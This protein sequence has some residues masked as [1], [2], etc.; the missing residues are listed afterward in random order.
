MKKWIVLKRSLPWGLLALLAVSLIVSCGGSGASGASSGPA[1]EKLAAAQ[2][3]NLL[4]FDNR[5]YTLDPADT[6]MPFE[7]LVI[8]HTIEGLFRTTVDEQGVQ[9]HEPAGAESYTVSDDGMVYTFKL[10]DYNW[11]D[12]KPVT[13]Q[14][15]VD[16][17]VRLLAPENAFDYVFQ[18][19][20]VKNAEAFY[21]KEVTADKLGIKALDDK[22]LEITLGTFSPF[23][24]DKLNL[25]PHFP[26]RLDVIGSNADQ[27][28]GSSV[29]KSLSSGPFK[30]SSWVKDNSIT[31]VKNPA[32]WDAANVKLEK[33][34]LQVVD[35]DSTRAQLFNNRQLD[36]VSGA[37][38]Y[39][40]TWKKQADSG[41]IVL[42][43]F[44]NGRLVRLDFPFN[45]GIAGLTD[46]K[47]I[48]Q[49]LSLSIDR[50]EAVDLAYNGRQV[51]AYGLLP[52]GLG[53][54]GRPA[55]DLVPEPL[56]GL[57]ARYV[58]DTEALRALFL[59]GLKE[60]GYSGGLDSITLQ[61]F[62]TDTLQPLKVLQEYL[63]QTWETR[64]GIHINI[65]IVADQGL[66]FTKLAGKQYD[67]ALANNIGADY[68][69]PLFWLSAWHSTG[70][71][72]TYF[73]GYNSPEFDA[74]VD[75]L[76]G[77][78]D[79]Q[80][81]AETYIAAEKRLIAE[82]W[83]VAPIFYTQL[84]FFIQPYVQNLKFPALSPYDFTRA[85]ILEH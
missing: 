39:Y 68:D 74:L 4:I 72:N 19:F 78:T 25:P 43:E 27:S 56:T 46:N 11:E 55:R 21:K 59:E 12:G 61:V 52:K 1:S 9:K 77:V 24:L 62:T 80:K 58:N 10:R 49:A 30:V 76:N 7:W 18:I 53:F 65:D 60:E 67:I 35:E 16:A 45:G 79:I 23:F 20:D 69:D 33:V 75:S 44:Y 57:A 40:E 37:A 32:Y 71:A 42:V 26:V 31:L 41:A 13:A 54:A 36:V 28:W 2:E 48:R 22:T 5:L 34:H 84:D 50:Q 17:I 63:K 64:L 85:Y 51:P 70:S 83:Q 14:H 82:D 38:D 66:A 73:G 47:K 81:R 29:E 3:L 8:S 6:K 15:Y